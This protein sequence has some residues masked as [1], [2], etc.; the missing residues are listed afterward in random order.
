LGLATKLVE[1]TA[2]GL[3]LAPHRSAGSEGARR[4]GWTG[5]ALAVLSV[6]VVSGCIVW[7]ASLIPQPTGGDTTNDH[8][9][10]TV[11][12]SHPPGRAHGHGHLPPTVDQRLAAA[13]LAAETRIGI[14]RY[15][16]QALA[17]ADGYR[18]VAL[19]REP[20]VHWE[21]RRAA[22]DGRTLDPAL[23]EQLVYA[24]TADGPLLLGAVFVMPRPDTAGPTVGGPLTRWHTH[25]L[26]IAPLPPWFAGL[27]SP[28]GACPV[29]S[30][31][32]VTAEMMH[33]WTVENPDGPFAEQLNEEYLRTLRRR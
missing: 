28:F 33:V 23:P 10:G 30:A 31:G 17:L 25:A 3:V 12:H 27:V 11:A 24:D 18:P 6:G 16:D 9:P 2:L 1:L 8:E 15:Q 4:R 32:I 13:R 22:R 21:N 29:L 26:C 19:G 5:A 20:V 14:A 7:G